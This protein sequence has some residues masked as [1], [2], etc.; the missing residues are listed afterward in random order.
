MD[1]GINFV[2]YS[3]NI[4]KFIYYNNFYI[5]IYIYIYI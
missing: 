5:Y 1:N 3:F 2:V 4:L